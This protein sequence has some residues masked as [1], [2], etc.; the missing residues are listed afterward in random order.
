MRGAP[1]P[2]RTTPSYSTTLVVNGDDFGYSD[3][4]NAAIVRC[5]DEGVL[6]STS[7]LVNRA[8]TRSAVVLARSRPG[9]GLGLH[10][11]LTEGGPVLPP[12]EVPSLVDRRGQFRSLGAQL[13][14]LLRGRTNLDEVERE[15]RA[16][17]AILLDAG[18][19][20]THVD[21][22]LHAHAFPGVLEIVVRLMAE[23][24][25]R[26]MRSPLIGAWLTRGKRWAEVAAFAGGGPGAR[27]RLPVGAALRTHAMG[28]LTGPRV[29]QAA[30]RAY[31][32]G[33]RA[34]LL[35]GAAIARAG[36]LFDAA[37]FLAAP[38]PALALANAVGVAPG[39]MVEVMAHPGW[40]RSATRGAAEVALLI[41]PRL[42]DLLAAHG[43]HSGHYGMTSPRCAVAQEPSLTRREG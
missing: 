5:Y 30:L 43:V 22:H 11:N 33:M 12:G 35:D 27:S 24:G 18:I 26:A 6:R 1:T 23:S 21:G 2:P 3:A 40:N 14:G 10:V 37:R 15:L 34:A 39:G 4:I 20:P 38:E 9:L 29:I 8:A 36:Y 32:D 31:P 41:D 7:L 16:Q 19:R 17:F 28:V 42:P 25:V 13:G